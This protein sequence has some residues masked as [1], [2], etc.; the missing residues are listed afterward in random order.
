MGQI[1]ELN[2]E[3]QLRRYGLCAGAAQ[4]ANL[5]GSATGGIG[6]RRQNLLLF[7]YQGV[8][9]LRLETV[10]VV[11]GRVVHRDVQ[12]KVVRSIVPGLPA[13]T[14]VRRARSLVAVKRL[15]HADLSLGGAHRCTRHFKGIEEALAQATG[16]GDVHRGDRVGECHIAGQRELRPGPRSQQRVG[17]IGRGQQRPAPVGRQVGKIVDVLPVGG[18]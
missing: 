4:A 12:R 3:M 2:L 7:D 8:G 13:Q 16:A 18:I 1:I 17:L 6:T 14:A 10:L 9:T 15:H 11:P 5:V